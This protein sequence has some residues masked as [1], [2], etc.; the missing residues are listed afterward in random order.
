MG[1]S[2]S[3]LAVEFLTSEPAVRKEFT[4]PVMIWEAPT[5]SKA[6]LILNTRAGASDDA[7]GGF[8]SQ[9]FPVSKR[10][11]KVDG[12]PGGVTIGHAESN[13][14]VIAHE[15][16]SRF[17]AYLSLDAQTKVWKVVDAESANGVWVNG[18]KLAPN[19]GAPLT[20]GARLRLGEIELLFLLPEAFFAYLTL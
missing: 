20:D 13:D 8:D 5:I 9:V 18:E 1:R 11:K 17:H 10:P 16:L 19:I 14:I 2:L 15:S 7:V 3:V 6:E 12:F 4:F